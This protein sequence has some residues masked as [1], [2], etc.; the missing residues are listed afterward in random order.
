M[1]QLSNNT[2]AL[3]A[4]LEAV[5]ALPE[6]GGVKAELKSASGAQAGSGT[7]AFSVSGLT[8]KPLF[9]LVVANDSAT[10]STL[11]VCVT[12]DKSVSV[13]YPSS[14]AGF[15]FLTLT[16]ELTDSGFTLTSTYSSRAVS[17]KTDRTYSWYA[18]G[19]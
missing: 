3:Q 16:T 2:T 7:T 14:S 4:L 5:E 11:L 18:Y 17:F 19:I 6:A 15:S 13:G 8:F 1:S 12:P 9:V 10:S